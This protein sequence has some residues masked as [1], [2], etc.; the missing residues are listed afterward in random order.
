MTTGLDASARVMQTRFAYSSHVRTIT[1]PNQ[2]PTIKAN[3]QQF[4]ISKLETKIAA[5]ERQ[6]SLLS[7]RNAELETQIHTPISIA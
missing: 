3:Q 6:V 2:S 5:L 7:A 4:K 1:V